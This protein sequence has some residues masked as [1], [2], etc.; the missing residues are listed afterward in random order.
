[1]NLLTIKQEFESRADDVVDDSQKT[2]WANLTYQQIIASYDNWPFMRAT[3]STTT[4]A[5][6]QEYLL[7]TDFAKP[8]KLIVNTTQYDRIDYEDRNMSGLSQK[9]YIKPSQ[10]YYGLVSSPTT[11]GDT[12]YLEYIKD[13][14][15][16][17]ADTD[18][19]VFEPR[20]HELLV[21]GMME[22]YHEKETAMGKAAFY[23]QQYTNLLAQMISYYT[24]YGKDDIIR[25]QTLAD[26]KDLTY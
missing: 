17:N 6:Q 1:M 18:Y 25:M 20:F 3:T 14:T 22:R 15:E 5:S 4:I 7:P 2:R 23:R 19:P 21:Y 8:I 24:R 12:I 10:D 9:Y 16:F 11:S 13:L 26:M